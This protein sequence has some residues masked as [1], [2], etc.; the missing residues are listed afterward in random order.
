[1][2][3][4]FLPRQKLDSTD[5]FMTKHFIHSYKVEVAQK[6]TSNKNVFLDCDFA[7]L[8][9]KKSKLRYDINVAELYDKLDE[10]KNS[11][12]ACTNHKTIHRRIYTF[13]RKYYPNVMFWFRTVEPGYRMAPSICGEYCSFTNDIKL[14]YVV[15]RNCST[16]YVQM[17]PR[18]WNKLKFNI[19]EVLSH[20]LVHYSQHM[21]SGNGFYKS[22]IHDFS[23]FINKQSFLDE[24]NYLSEDIELEAFAH[25]AVVER[26]RYKNARTYYRI[27]EMLHILKSNNCPQDK[28]THITTTFN[29]SLNFWKQLYKF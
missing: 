9:T 14:V 16:D 28:I 8:L 6:A 20:E 10:L 18:S 4:S 5:L 26:L 13:F 27:S 21:L 2:H 11:I 3:P 29:N 23:E 22:K 12:F 15:D 19:C 24:C 7:K 1:M 25:T 17:T